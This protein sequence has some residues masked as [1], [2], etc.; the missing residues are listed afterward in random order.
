MLSCIEKGDVAGLRKLNNIRRLVNT[1]IHGTFQK[2]AFA[3]TDPTP[4]QFAVG[5]DQEEVVELLLG[6]GA[7][8]NDMGDNDWNPVH[9]AIISG[10]ES[11]L[12]LLL[13]NGGDVNKMDAF[14]M[15][16]IFLA[17]RMSD[18]C[19]ILLPILEHFPDKSVRY[20]GNTALHYAVVE[21]KIQHVK[22][23]LSYDYSVDDLNKQ[24][25]TV[26]EFAQGRRYGKVLE[27]LD[28]PSERQRLAMLPKR[29][30]TYRRVEPI[31]DPPPAPVTTPVTKPEPEQEPAKPEPAPTPTPTPTQ[32]TAP[33]IEPVHHPEPQMP[34]IPQMPQYRPPWPPM[35]A[36]GG[37]GEF[38]TVHRGS[39]ES[40]M[41]RVCMLEA[42]VS[43]LARQRQ[44]QP[45]SVCHQPC[46]NVCPVCHKH[47]CDPHFVQHIEPSCMKH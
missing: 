16:P 3:L 26:I 33:V 37:M 36:Y 5:C 30:R 41:S 11:I 25:Q 21:N 29:E 32:V 31:V 17:L 9:M 27:I 46:T 6:Y 8:P 13:D 1:K 38:I 43:D 34:Q 24:K 47:F 20:Q 45:C 15:S 12:T 10:N 2:G 23:L 44:Q 18:Q 39:Y 14:G 40:L 35:D 4:M 42:L 7:D 22:M 19:K 28:N